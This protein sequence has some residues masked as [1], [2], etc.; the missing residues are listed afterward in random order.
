MPKYVFRQMIND[1]IWSLNMNLINPEW[2]VEW[3]V[4][5]NGMDEA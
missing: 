1:K 3:A 2:L 4:K 5:Q